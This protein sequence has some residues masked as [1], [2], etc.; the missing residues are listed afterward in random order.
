MRRKICLLLCLVMI[1][2][3]NQVT[4]A[5]SMPEN[6]TAKMIRSGLLVESHAKVEKNSKDASASAVSPSGGITGL[7]AWPGLANGSYYPSL[8]VSKFQD[9]NTFCSL[10]VPQNILDIVNPP[11]AGVY[12][13]WWSITSFRTP[14][15][16]KS[17]EIYLNDKLLGNY[18]VSGGTVYDFNYFASVLD[19]NKI[20]NLQ[21][22]YD[23]KYGAHV[24]V[25][26]SNLC[27]FNI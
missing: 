3:F 11:R 21:I 24:Y 23:T 9:N 7:Q 16:A 14:V 20:I 26:I 22:L 13:G 19:G 17:V 8:G 10:Y 5:S 4:F 1:C 27:L 25:G 18:S 12:E 15:D 6:S 2:V